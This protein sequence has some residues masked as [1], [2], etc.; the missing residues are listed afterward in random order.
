MEISVR[1]EILS[2]DDV[3]GTG[4]ISGDDSLRYG[5]GRSAIQPGGVIAVG[6]RVD[7]VPEGATATQILILAPTRELAL[8]VAEACQ[9]YAKHMP[10]F[11][12]LP[13]YGGSSYET[14]TRALRRGA[15]VVVGTPGRVMD[16]IRRKNLDLSGLKA[17]VLDEADE[18]LRMGFIDDVDWIM[19]QCP[20]TRQV[21]LFS[22]TMPD[23]IQIGRAHV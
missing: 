14:Q 7:F 20:A 9:R 5:F 8:Q 16:L 21:A 15:Q 10:D 11:H 3:S 12:D 17:L 23:Q 6:A 22:A 2:Y 4:L 1:G 13:I 19:E 18:M